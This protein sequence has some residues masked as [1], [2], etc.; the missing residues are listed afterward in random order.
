MKY[1]VILSLLYGCANFSAPHS[2][3]L[4]NGTTRINKSIQTW[5]E[6]LEQ[7]VIMQKTD[8]SC[9]AGAMATL[10][11]YYFADNITEEII[12]Q[13]ISSH[14][15]SDEMKIR[16]KD[17]FSMFDLQQFAKRRGY[18]AVGI[19][20]KPATLLKLR[21]PVLVYVE[22][23]GY[24]HFAIL[25]GVKN[26]LVFLADPSRG[27]LRMSIEDFTKEWKGVT[28]VLGKKG[29]GTPTEHKLSVQE[30]ELIKNE[31]RIVRNGLYH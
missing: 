24:K 28:L 15:S 27:N 29:F 20:L 14:L 18:K 26:N 8:Y 11:H 30:H 31:L 23:K 25:R 16:K 21:G 19:K 10:M 22:T 6:I 9:G 4:P 13:D 7:N 17:G 5:K 12:L 1:F 3:V 2:T